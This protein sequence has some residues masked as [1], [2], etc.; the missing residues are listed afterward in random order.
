MSQCEAHDAD[1]ELGALGV[2]A[3]PEQVFAARLVTVR[4]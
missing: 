2:A 4:C 3:Q 1:H